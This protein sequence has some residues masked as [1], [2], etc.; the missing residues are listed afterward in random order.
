MEQTQIERTILKIVTLV[1]YEIVQH[2][3]ADLSA[4]DR[5]VAPIS[6]CRQSK[7]SEVNIKNNNII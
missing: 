1:F 3:A 5:N 7:S 2:T 4:E 6:L